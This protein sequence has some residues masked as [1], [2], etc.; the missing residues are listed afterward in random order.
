MTKLERTI[1]ILKRGWTTSLECAQQGGVMSL[2]QR[3]NLDLRPMRTFEYAGKFLLLDSVPRFDIDE[4]WVQ[5]KGGA[6]VKAWRITK[7]RGAK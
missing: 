3:V 7:D 4:K 6:R 1:D 2:S 5:T